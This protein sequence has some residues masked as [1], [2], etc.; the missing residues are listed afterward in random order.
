MHLDIRKLRYSRAPWRIGLVHDDGR[1]QELAHCCFDRKRDAVPV[2]AALQALDAPWHVPPEQGPAAL[3]EHATAL[4]HQT[5]GSQTWLA[6]VQRGPQAPGRW[7]HEDRAVAA[8]AQEAFLLKGGPCAADKPHEGL[9][10]SWHGNPYS[11][12]DPRWTRASCLSISW[13]Q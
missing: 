7:G 8:F 6:A 11:T 1:F 5:P 13:S 4:L 9:G 2:L 12:G 3:R 10:A